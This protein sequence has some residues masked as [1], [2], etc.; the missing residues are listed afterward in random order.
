MN[1]QPFLRIKKFLR[2]FIQTKGPSFY[3]KQK[4]L[5]LVNLRLMQTNVIKDLAGSIQLGREV[6]S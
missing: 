6:V 5:Q 4:L 2:I 3:F 1:T